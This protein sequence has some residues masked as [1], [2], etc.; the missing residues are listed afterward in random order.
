M[1]RFIVPAYNERR[2]I[3][4]VLESI[5][6]HAPEDW[7]CVV[8]DDGSTDGTGEALREL[9]REHGDQ[10]VVRSH[11][12]NQGVPATLLDGYR[13]AASAA[14]GDD[15]IFCIEGDNTSDP[16]LFA[17]MTTRLRGGADVAIASRYVAGGSMSGFP[18]HRRL[19][20][21]WGNAVLRRLAPT[22]GVNDFSIFFRGYRASLV[23]R[24][25]A[26]HDGAAFGGRNFSSNTVFLLRCLERD[27][28]V[29]EVPSH[30]AYE[31]KEGDSSFSV[32]RAAQAYAPL[33]ARLAWKRWGSRR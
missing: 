3:A 30:Y 16:R 21:E 11:V 7:T 24:V 33:F 13:A 9:Q 20:S 25:L 2:N 12:T 29:A 8:V 26:D 10:L 23:Q 5:A 31:L 14:D 19:V 15:L 17:P 27:P 22:A 6:H 4:G 1:I 18:R 32:L 28:V